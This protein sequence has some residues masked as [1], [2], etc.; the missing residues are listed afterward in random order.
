MKQHKHERV[1]Q[2]MMIAWLAVLLCLCAPMFHAQHAH[3]SQRKSSAGGCELLPEK[4]EKFIKSFAAGV[5]G[6]QYCRFRKIARGDINADGIADLIVVFTVEGACD[7]DKSTPPG[8]CGNHHETYLKVFLGKELKEVPL[9]MVGSRGDRLITG[10]IVKN[11]VIEAETLAYGE[12]DPMC[13]PSI[14]GKTRFVLTKD[15]LMEEHL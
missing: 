9:L 2:S 5:R 15:V 13:C 11:G 8:A 6:A 14:K 7:D 10:L 4:V 3:A 12:D 1:R